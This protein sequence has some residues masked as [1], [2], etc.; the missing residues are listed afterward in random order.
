[1]SA[2]SLLIILVVGAIAGGEGVGEV[3]KNHGRG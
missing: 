2:E 1:M 3:V